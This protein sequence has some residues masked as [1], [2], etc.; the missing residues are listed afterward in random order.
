M[1]VNITSILLLKNSGKYVLLRPASNLRR[2]HQLLQSVLC[3]VHSPSSYSQVPERNRTERYTY[4]AFC[5]DW[6][7]IPPCSTHRIYICAS[8]PASIEDL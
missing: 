3:F 1:Y 8:E 4:L 2:G 5:I 6:I 7:E